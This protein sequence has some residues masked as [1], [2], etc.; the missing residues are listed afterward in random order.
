M[1]HALHHG[2]F[3]REGGATGGPRTVLWVHGLGESGLCFEGLLDRTDLA[4]WRH[5]A[6]DL[7]GYGRTAWPTAPLS[8]ADHADLL[9]DLCSDL[10]TGPVV[11]AGHSMG[12]IVALLLAERHRS[13]VRGVVDIDGNK[14]PED[15]SFSGQAVEQDV[16]DFVAG[17]FDALRGRV[18]EAGV[19]DPAQRGYYASLRQA[20]P[21]AYHLNSGELVAMAAKAGDLAGRLAAL[22]CPRVYI[23]GAPRGVCAESRRLL[24][25]ARVPVL[26]VAPSGHWP[27]VDQPDTFAAKLREFLDEVG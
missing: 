15:C 13:L 17:G 5:L 24:E 3:L 10:G 18:Y 2:V 9:A 23:A 20:D 11:V 14:S 6:P 16:G 19:D 21:V 1:R 26:E 25:E 22:S 27:F 7:P 8:L 12:G 4:G